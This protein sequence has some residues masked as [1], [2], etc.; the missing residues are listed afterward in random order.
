MEESPTPGSTG[1]ELRR[2]AQGAKSDQLGQ[3]LR[4][5]DPALLDWA[6]EHIFGDVWARPGLAF[7]ERMMVA[8]VAL[9]T[10]GHTAQLRN[11]FHGALQEGIPE[12]KLKEALL[13]LHVYAGFPAAIN[14]LV[15][16][17]EALRAHRSS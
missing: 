2:R 10:A 9:A 17:D 1:R 8:I 3:A 7:E 4:A 13:M 12:V 14:A 5:V 16:L 11:Y 15:V 6:D